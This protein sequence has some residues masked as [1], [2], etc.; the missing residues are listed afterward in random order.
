MLNRI[1]WIGLGA[2]LALAPLSAFA[3]TSHS[4]PAASSASTIPNRNIVESDIELVLTKLSSIG[5][6]GEEPCQG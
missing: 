4:A 3:L 6:P 5:Y 1:A 2:V